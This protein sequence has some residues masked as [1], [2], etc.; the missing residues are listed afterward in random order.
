MGGEGPSYSVGGRIRI[1]DGAASPTVTV[2]ITGSDGN[3]ECTTLSTEGDKWRL[4]DYVTTAPGATGY[5]KV[6]IDGSEYHLLAA[7]S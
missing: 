6:I 5:V 2:D 7:A 1:T 4:F 3:I